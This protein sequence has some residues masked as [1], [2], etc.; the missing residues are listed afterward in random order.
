MKKILCLLLILCL[1]SCTPAPDTFPAKDNAEEKKPPSEPVHTL[2]D[3]YIIF[4]YNRACFC[5]CDIS[6]EEILWKYNNETEYKYILEKIYLPHSVTVELHEWIDSESFDDKYIHTIS[7]YSETKE[8]EF[9][10][11]LTP[12][13][14]SDT[15]F[16]KLNQIHLNFEPEICVI[17]GVWHYNS[18]TNECPDLNFRSE[19]IKYFSS[20]LEAEL[21]GAKMCL[22]CNDSYF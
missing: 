5:V 3:A 4:D 21:Y 12:Y 22:Y 10:I 13:R 17:N 8:G 2:Y 7:I 19:N 20:P 16:E 9:D 11:I 18:D 15:S 1:S 14:S 6:R